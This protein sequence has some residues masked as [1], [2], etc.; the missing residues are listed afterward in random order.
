MPPN[1]IITK[2]V[3][4]GAANQKRLENTA[5]DQWFSTDGSRPTFGSCALTFGSPK[6]LF[7]TIIQTYGLPNCVLLS[8][9]GRQQPNVEK[10]SSRQVVL[11]VETTASHQR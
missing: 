11:N 2:Y 7:S 8:F 1:I 5:L 6:P 3:C 10:P 9:V 4:K